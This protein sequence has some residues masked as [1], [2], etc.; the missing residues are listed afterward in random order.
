MRQLRASLIL[1]GFLCLTLPLMPVQ[2]VWVLLDSRAARLLPWF[3]HRIL[4]RLLG[5]HIKVDGPIPTAPALLVSNHVSWLDIPVLSSVMPLSFIAKREVGG[6]PMFGWMAKLQRCVFVNREIRYS[7]GKSSAEIT[8]R[9]HAGDTLVLFP[10]G[11]SNDGNTVKSFKSSYFGAAENLDIPVVPVTVAYRSNYNLAFTKR[12][13][14][15]VA[16]YGD[17]DLVP[18]LWEFLKAGPIKVSVRF[19]EALP[20]IPRKEMANMAQATIVKSLTETLHGQP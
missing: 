6:W 13:R 14:P 17:M 15:R 2:L 5:V 10:E 8:K 1:F 4:C 11:T 16:W 3:Y 19:H 7:T 12:Q 9:L 18:H 20:K